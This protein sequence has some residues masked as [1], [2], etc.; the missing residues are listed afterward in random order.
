[1][2]HELIE[3]LF[4]PAFGAG[5]QAPLLDS[6]ILNM[7][8]GAE[9]EH[10]PVFST[11]SFVVNPLFFPGGDIGSLAVHGTVNDLAM[12]GARPL[13][14]SAG[15]I[16]EE[17][18][19]METLG[20]VVTSMAAAAR[21]AGVRII[22]GDTKVVERGHG[23]GIYINTSGVGLLPAPLVLSPHRVAAGD[24]ILVN[25]T[26]GDH[27]IAI[28][29]QRAGLEFETEIVSDSAALH[30][31]VETM[32]DAAPS[33][34]M[35]RDLTRGGLSAA[36]NEIARDARVGLVVDEADVP[37][38]PAVA[39]ACDLL[40]LDPFY[41]ANEGKLLAMVP[42]RD[43]PEVLAAMRAHPLG[44]YAARIGTVTAENP[45]VVI[46]RT[47]IGGQ[48]VIDLPAGELLPRIC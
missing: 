20:N 22:T 1:M 17:G 30:G 13:Y 37:V 14:L 25:G 31:L 42:E 44:R 16:L 34:H 21:D 5:D 23:D 18:L 39:A 46:G 27:G 33:I 3:H 26:L 2:T 15:F 36:L 35:L 19:P 9:S 11:D 48:R 24:A 12:L 10:R 32:L 40:G 47:A 38:Q 29:S 8:V 7:N 45:G 43:A 28:M 6:A 4:A 41:V